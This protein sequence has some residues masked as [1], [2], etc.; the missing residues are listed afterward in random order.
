MWNIS[1]SGARAAK[2]AG[3]LLLASAF[4][5]YLTWDQFAA[6]LPSYQ[7][8][9][10]ASLALVGKPLLF[11]DLY[12]TPADELDARQRLWRVLFVLEPIAVAIAALVW[13]VS[14]PAAKA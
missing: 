9:G 8:L 7:F 3:A 2:I 1:A 4:A 5:L 14:N 10:L 12:R 6:H 11:V 13:L